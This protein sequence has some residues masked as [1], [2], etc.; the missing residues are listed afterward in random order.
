MSL[1]TIPAEE[2]FLKT[3]AAGILKESGD[4]GT[5]LPV[6]KILLPNRRS[7]QNLR[8]TFLDISDGKILLLPQIRP[9]GEVEEEE[10]YFSE[11]PEIAESLAKIPP[12]IS[13]TRRQ[14]LLARLIRRKEE[15]D[16]PFD[17]ILRLAQ[18]LG[19][20]LDQV[21]IEDVSFDALSQIV[22]EEFADHWQIT[23][24]F[25]EI[26]RTAWPEILAENGV[27]EAAER[28]N[29]LLHLQA[30]YWQA[31]PPQTPII[32]AG[33]TGTMPATARLM[34]VIAALPCGQVVLPGLDLSMDEESWSAME[35]SHPQA[36]FKDFLQKIERTRADVTIYG[37][38][39]ISPTPRQT[40][41]TDI[42]RP[43]ETIHI[44]REEKTISKESFEKDLEK[45]R[46]Y[47]CDTTRQEAVVIALK[48]RET[49]EDPKK[50][51]ALVTPDRALAQQVRLV[52]ERWGITLDDT[53]GLPLSQTSLGSFL[54]LPLHLLQE[55]LR[56]AL[57]LA[58]LKHPLCALGLSRAD[59]LRDISGIDQ[60]LRGPVPKTYAHLQDFA[61]F[62]KL[63]ALAEEHALFCA[64]DKHPVEAY[65][66]AHLQCLEA[67][68]ATDEEDGAQRLWI[69]DD[70]EA[71][72]G[73]FN[74]L[75]Q[76]AAG[77][78]TL[79]PQEYLEMFSLLLGS[80][81]VRPKYGTHPRLL[82][83]GQIEARLLKADVMVL[84]GLNEGT[85]P[86]LPEADPWMSRPMREDFGLPDL[87]RS[88][89]LSAHDFIQAF[90][91]KDVTLTRTIRQ[92][93]TP[94]VPARWL[95]R[96]D[97]VLKAYGLDPQLIRQGPFKDWAVQIDKPEKEAQPAAR[98][99]P[100]P[101][102]SRRPT[103]LP[104]TAIES[105]MRDPYSLYAKY[106]LELRPMEDV[107]Q[108]ADA[109]LRGQWLHDVFEWFVR[110]YPTTI[111]ATALHEMTD[112]ALA[113]DL[114]PQ[115]YE[116]F[117]PRLQRLL[118]WFVQQETK[119]REVAEVMPEA[120]EAKGNILMGDFE[121]SAKADRIDRMKESGA[122]AIIDYKT[123]RVPSNP[124]II[125][126]LSPQMS[127]EGLILQ[128]NS[129]E[130][131]SVRGVDTLRFWKLGGGM[132]AGE[133][134]EVK[135]TKGMTL[136]DIL[137]EAEEGLRNLIEEF[138][139]EETPYISLPDSTKTPPEEWQDYAHLARVQEWSTQDDGEAA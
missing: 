8:D 52:C 123:G 108:N 34:G 32:A 93:G 122:G 91:S 48:L 60:K 19:R 5:P 84:G 65:I 21:I 121:L 128:Q 136:E 111:P 90:A 11:T 14:F 97:V 95:Q 98:P 99:A 45:M 70:G 86:A 47:E 51:A 89:A 53:G 39:N 16:R 55:R 42:M 3:L 109:A 38:A 40:L 129:F 131:V 26:L 67:L 75:L 101:L 118:Q 100:A 28:R 56:P 120:L 59:V 17:Q 4:N 62:Q 77:M 139:K 87:D 126:G 9:L 37:A 134:K 112:Y 29:R 104:V 71:A 115:D 7:C 76:D 35:P 132:T 46:L 80:V 10:L 43:A 12:A 82:I 117:L 102:T 96:L 79:S 2:N 63:T 125:K 49:L 110:T 24:D 106:I 23:L 105:W 44:W 135:G 50:T 61:A 103:S 18:A 138:S 36:L 133:E 68:A 25:L 92:E 78:G 20:L 137:R 15:K 73:F 85:W 58:L 72:A 41:I 114:A 127:L 113:S 57:F 22:P 94:S 66:H 69:S 74:Q 27:I 13:A 30:A 124:E 130:G 64:H 81:L 88:V 6:Y 31:H 83:A 116:V 33:S 54:T 107:E 1:L 119:W